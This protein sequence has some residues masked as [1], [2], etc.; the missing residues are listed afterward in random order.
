MRGGEKQQWMEKQSRSEAIS[1]AGVYRGG[2]VT[3][4]TEGAW[5][6]D[7][8]YHQGQMDPFNVQRAVQPWG[9]YID[10]NHI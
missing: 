10:L 1:N 8:S 6:K 7:Q 3:A 5:V 9:L 4:G 2:N